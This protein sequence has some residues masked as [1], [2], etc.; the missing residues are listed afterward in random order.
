[1]K[2]ELEVPDQ[3][4]AG[5][6]PERVAKRIKLYAAMVMLQTGEL[7]AGAAAELAGVSRYELVLECARRGV[8][9][10]DYA[11]SELAEELDAFRVE[12][13]A[14]STPQSWTRSMPT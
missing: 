3:Y 8:P 2:I 5:E 11:A 7:S 12:R 9:T 10:V 13:R 4:I 14:A 1:M 6:D